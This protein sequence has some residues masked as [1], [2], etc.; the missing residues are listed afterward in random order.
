M[1]DNE[2]KSSEEKP[3]KAISKWQ[4]ASVKINQLRWQLHDAL[5]E[6]F[7]E[8]DMKS[9]KYEQLLETLNL[10]M[11]HVLEKYKAEER[12]KTQAEMAKLKKK[13]S[14]SKWKTIA[15]CFA[16]AAIAQ[17][18]SILVNWVYQLIVGTPPPGQ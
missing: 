6:G 2:A 16:G 7:N 17:A 8:E 3:R 15:W 1:S 9:E 14:W 5:I 10:L 18:G 4:L 11:E 12:K 13:A